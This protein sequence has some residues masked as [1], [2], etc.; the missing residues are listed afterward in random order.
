MSALPPILPYLTVPDG[1]GAIEFYKKAFGAV[2]QEVHDAPGT[3]KVMNACLSING[4][5]FILS[6]DFSDKTGGKPETPEALG[7]TP[8]MIHLQ[9]PDVDGA[10]ERAVAAGA[11]VVLPLADQFCGDRYGQLTDP[12]GH[13]WSMS[14]TKVSLTK[15]EI[16]EAAKTSFKM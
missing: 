11:T 4:G 8:V 14:Q 15:A 7:G 12:F 6:D 13:K 9:V 3:T 10:W 1:A 2:V 5:V 16:E